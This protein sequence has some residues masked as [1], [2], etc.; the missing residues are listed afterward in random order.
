MYK[1][2]LRVPP[3]LRDMQLIM[4]NFISINIVTNSLLALKSLASS[5]AVTYL[6]VLE[7]ISGKAS[8]WLHWN[9]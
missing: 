7:S 6:H 8:A 5:L 1:G 4:P 2:V 3:Q 9:W